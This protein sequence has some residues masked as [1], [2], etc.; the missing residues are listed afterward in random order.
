MWLI[1]LYYWSECFLL[2]ISCLQRFRWSSE[3]VSTNNKAVEDRKKFE[4]PHFL[5]M[6]DD[7]F[8]LFGFYQPS[9]TICF[10]ND[11]IMFMFVQ[12][13]KIS[14]RYTYFSYYF[15]SVSS[16]NSEASN[17]EVGSTQRWKEAKQA[18][19]YY[20]TLKRWYTETK[21]KKGEAESK[22]G[23]SSQGANLG[24]FCWKLTGDKNRDMFW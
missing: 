15:L 19:Y 6:E 14:V 22:T 16:W 23:F 7:L 20:T 9:L 2:C 21:A 13:P 24:S 17:L 4:C 12:W 11:N 3:N 18:G 1:N 5:N 10:D 8:E